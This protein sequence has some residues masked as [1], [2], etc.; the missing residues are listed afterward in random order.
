MATQVPMATPGLLQQPM[1]YVNLGLLAPQGQAQRLQAPAPSLGQAPDALGG[2]GEGAQALGQN[3]LQ[4]AKAQREAGLQAKRSRLLGFQTQA[5]QLDLDQ[6][7]QEKARQEA[8]FGA[9]G[10]LEKFVERL[11][12][13][14]NAAREADNRARSQRGMPGP[15]VTA[16]PVAEVASQELPPLGLDASAQEA[17]AMDPG[18]APAPT[19]T[20]PASDQ[21]AVERLAKAPEQPTVMTSAG[22]VVPLSGQAEPPSLAQ[23]LPDGVRQHALAMIEQARHLQD[24][25]MA[26]KAFKLI[27]EYGDPRVAQKAAQP[28]YT[29]Y[30]KDAREFERAYGA[31][32]TLLRNVKQNTSVSAVGAIKNYFA[33]LEPGL[34]V[35]DA[36][37]QSIVEGQSIPEKFQIGILKGFAGKPFSKTFAD[38]LQRSAQAAIQ[39]RLS[40][41]ERRDARTKAFLDNVR[42]PF[43]GVLT[44]DVVRTIKA[45]LPAMGFG[46]T[47]QFGDMPTFEIP[48]ALFDEKLPTSIAVA[49]WWRSLSP[50]QQRGA[51]R[52]PY[53]NQVY[54]QMERSREAEKRVAADVAKADAAI[55]RGN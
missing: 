4:M 10:T 32:D 12:L 19:V 36:E 51:V 43:V 25:E 40:L 20:M 8:Y 34:Q 29:E 49:E 9:G 16:A 5:A 46:H 27:A 39:A 37:A 7:E 21:L 11:D 15:A 55:R 6:K 17:F 44:P 2:L 54:S 31:Y 48:Q 22:E 50:E 13:G 53:W 35:T 18:A 45:D 28:I 38:A 1:P 24:G 30:N 42:A 14:S 3:L 52:L 23:T 41:Q 47:S 33:I 26:A